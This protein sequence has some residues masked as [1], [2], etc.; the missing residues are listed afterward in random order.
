M[1]LAPRW[2]RFAAPDRNRNVVL[3]DLRHRTGPLQ[4]G[5]RRSWAHHL[6]RDRHRH[7]QSRGFGPGRQP[8]FRQDRQA[9]CRFQLHRERRADPGSDRS[10]TLQGASTPGSRRDEKRQRQSRQSQEHGRAAQTRTGPY[11]SHCR[12]Q[13]FVSQADLDLAE[14]N[15]RDAAAHMEVSQAQLDQAEAALASAELDLGYTTIYS[16]VNGIVVSRN[17][18]VGQTVAATFQTPILFVIAQDLTKMEVT[19]TSAKPTSAGVSR[20]QRAQLSRRRV[21]QTVL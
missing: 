4:N 1:G 6:S 16:P 2:W 13:A 12:P 19:R 14:T 10:T 5:G 15:Y 3:V 20:R 7:R 11:G 21:S 9:L 18:D 8:N 17:V